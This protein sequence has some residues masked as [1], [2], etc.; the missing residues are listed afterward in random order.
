[1]ISKLLLVASL[2][3][4]L[5]A[6]AD[7][8]SGWPD[9]PVRLIVPFTAGG[10]TDLLGRLVADGLGK[11]MGQSVVVVNKGGAGG[12]L[13]AAEVARSEPDGYTLL[14]GT[15]GTQVINALVYKNIGYDSQKDLT[16]VAYIAQ[17]PNVVLTNPSTGIKT[18][19]DLLRV[20]RSK[21]GELHWGSPGVGSTA[22][23]VLELIRRTGKVDIGH[24]PYKGASQANSDL[25]GG[26]IELSGDNLPT[27][28]PF[29]K[30][31]KLV[32]LGVTA[33]EAVPVLQ[34][35]KPIGATLPGFELT[36]WFVLMAP[37]GTRPETIATLNGAVERVLRTP[38]MRE[39]LSKIGATP[40]G[41]TPD[42][43]AH[44]LEAERTKYRQL[45]Q[46]AGIR[47]E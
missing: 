21:P 34:G 37:K 30:S 2:A 1:M 27:A 5:A 16:P 46:G 28:L 35:V 22:H 6:P 42:A 14:L 20:A 33:K 7:A 36:S 23:M 3:L 38:H 19:E 41:G 17:V 45:I 39:Q 32:A 26:Q 8:A 31:G 4:S 40:V 11:E 13:G 9:K 44:H 24:V 10:T 43:L 12:S 18:M 47:P 15:P 29:I 25:L